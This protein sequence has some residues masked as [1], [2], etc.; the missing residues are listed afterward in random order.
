MGFVSLICGKPKRLTRL[1]RKTFSL[2]VIPFQKLEYKYMNAP[3]SHKTLDQHNPLM[4]WRVIEQ[5]TLD[6][7]VA[8]A[9]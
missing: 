7:T 2:T 4:Q 6:L 5:L 1:P 9:D 3:G 8:T